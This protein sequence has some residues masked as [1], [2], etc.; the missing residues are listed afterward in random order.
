MGTAPR[1]HLVLILFEPVEALAAPTQLEIGS[2]KDRKRGA[3][4]DAQEHEE[5]DDPCNGSGAGRDK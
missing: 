4:S 5:G 3:E 1:K 2:Q